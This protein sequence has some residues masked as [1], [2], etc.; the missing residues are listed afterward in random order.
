MNFDKTIFLFKRIINHIVAALDSQVESLHTQQ[1]T[2]PAESLTSRLKSHKYKFMMRKVL[3]R[4][5]MNGT[6]I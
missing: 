5:H 6:E 4:I 1:T 2:V 3:Y